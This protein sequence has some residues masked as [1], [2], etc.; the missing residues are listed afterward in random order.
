MVYINKKYTDHEYLLGLSEEWFYLFVISVVW[1][2]SLLVC[3]TSLQDPNVHSVC[4][5]IDD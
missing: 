2:Q 3:V 1:I 5:V 4:S